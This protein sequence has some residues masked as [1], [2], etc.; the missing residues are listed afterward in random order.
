[1]LQKLAKT[2]NNKLLL[3][4]AI[5]TISVGGGTIFGIAEKTFSDSCAW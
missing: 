4:A 5:L 3:V 2:M 1:M